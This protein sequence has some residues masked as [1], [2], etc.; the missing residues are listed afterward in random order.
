MHSKEI[1][2]GHEIMVASKTIKRGQIMMEVI[3]ME[4][5]VMEEDFKVLDNLDSEAILDFK[6][7]VYSIILLIFTKNKK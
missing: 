6:N 2:K 7:D 1:V 4:V 5:I 3:A